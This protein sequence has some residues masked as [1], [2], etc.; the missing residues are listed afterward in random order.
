MFFRYTKRA[1]LVSTL[2]LAMVAPAVAQTTL[3]TVLTDDQYN[4]GSVSD[5]GSR[6]VAAVFA[7]ENEPEP[8]TQFALDYYA[9]MLLA[10]WTIELPSELE[11][12]SL[13][14]TSA[15]ITVYSEKEADWDPTQGEPHLYAVGFLHGD[16]IA[17]WDEDTPYEG[18]GNFTPGDRNPFV[19]DLITNDNVQ[20][21]PSGTPWSVGLI[22]PS[23]EGTVATSPEPFSITFTLD[24]SDPTIQAELLDH[25]AG[26]E[27]M[28]AVVSTYMA[29]F[30]GA[31]GP[32]TYP[33]VLTKEGA[34]E[35]SVGLPFMAPSL[36]IEVVETTSVSDWHMY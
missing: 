28:W 24:V 35:P 30:S 31:P 36:E 4:Y 15:T 29:S 7:F 27:S 19:R 8:A 17:D 14:V 6:Q 13:E 26:G 2:A 3:N 5:G 23:Y 9:G 25:I 18:P 20:R 34:A 22:D 12:A 10:K 21:D 1:G 33:R 32:Q 16:T 11:G